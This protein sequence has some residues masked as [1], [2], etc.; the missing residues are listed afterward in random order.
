MSE[1]QFCYYFI[2][3]H[4]GM[5]YHTSGFVHVSHWAPTERLPQEIIP[6]TTSYYFSY[7]G[8]HISFDTLYCKN[9]KWKTDNSERVK[10]WKGSGFAVE[11]TWDL[12]FTH[13]AHTL[14]Y[15]DCSWNTDPSSAFVCRLSKLP[16]RLVCVRFFVY[17]YQAQFVWVALSSTPTFLKLQMHCHWMRER[18]KIFSENISN[19]WAEIWISLEAQGVSGV[20]LHFLEALNQL[21]QMKAHT[22]PLYNSETGQA[23]GNYREL[24]EQWN[25][26][27]TYYFMLLKFWIHN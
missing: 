19:R 11:S 23:W 12:H 13:S 14:M 8:R 4:T 18:N 2:V 25:N 26:R 1:I 17:I 9:G 10:I 5:W 27:Q 20:L 21:W 6:Q 7:S 16:L 22:K 24:S 15:R 3:L